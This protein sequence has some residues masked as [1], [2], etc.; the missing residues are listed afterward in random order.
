MDRHFVMAVRTPEGQEPE[1]EP[2]VISKGD[3]WLHLELDD[4]ELIQLPIDEI[5]AA[6]AD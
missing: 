5:S 3:G 1:S 4:G 6:I 2:I